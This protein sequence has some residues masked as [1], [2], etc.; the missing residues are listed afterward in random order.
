MAALNWAIG[1]VRAAWNE[2]LQEVNESLMR[3]GPID[4]GTETADRGAPQVLTYSPFDL[5]A[6]TPVPPDEANAFQN[7]L[8]AVD[9]LAMKMLKDRHD[10]GP[11][12]TSQYTLSLNEDDADS[13]TDASELAAMA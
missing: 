11:G 2:S 10:N 3:S 9:A 8:D 6:Y 12:A 4:I 1:T 7:S 13:D 5:L